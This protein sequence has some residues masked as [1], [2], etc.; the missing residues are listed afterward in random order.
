MLGGFTGGQGDDPPGIF[1]HPLYKPERSQ[2]SQEREILDFNDF[3]LLGRGVQELPA[4]LLEL[5]CLY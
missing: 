3:D 5:K 2:L 4:G 1:H